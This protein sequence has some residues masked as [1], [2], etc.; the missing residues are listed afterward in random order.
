[1]RT[2]LIGPPQVDLVLLGA[3][4]VVESGGIINAV[5][6]PISCL[7]SDICCFRLLTAACCLPV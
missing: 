2:P 1:M 7:L 5:R 6:A 4:A 3:E